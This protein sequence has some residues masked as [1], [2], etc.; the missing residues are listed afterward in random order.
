MFLDNQIERSAI[1]DTDLFPLG[2]ALPFK[3]QPS[4]ALGVMMMSY[5]DEVA[6]LEDLG[7]EV[8]EALKR[9]VKGKMKEWIPGADT[10]ESFRD[11]EALWDAVCLLFPPL[12][13]YS[14]IFDFFGSPKKLAFC[15]IRRTQN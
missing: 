3:H 4:C 12:S 8:D 6:R 7:R 14:W 11:A 5:L 13:I 2:L 10:E 15:T 9:E 1:K